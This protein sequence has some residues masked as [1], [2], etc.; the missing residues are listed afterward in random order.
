MGPMLGASA[1]GRGPAFFRRGGP[2]ALQQRVETSELVPD[3]GPPRLH[4]TAGAVLVGAR[5]PLIAFNVNLRGGPPGAA[6]EIAALVR[7]TV[8]SRSEIVHDLTKP[9]GTPRK[10]LD[11]T[12][13]HD[14]GWDAKIGL[15][16]GIAEAYGWFVEN[17]PDA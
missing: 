3:F 6:K 2:E 1:P 14:L 17:H 16:T 8:G 10:L 12:R 5:K 13:L 9:D 11:T 4:E 7:E 15:R